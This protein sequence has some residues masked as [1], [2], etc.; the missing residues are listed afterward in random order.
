M[1][2]SSL[3]YDREMIHVRDDH[4]I[5]MDAF[6]R[7]RGRCAFDAKSTSFLAAL[8]AGS[9]W[10][11]HAYDHGAGDRLVGFLRAISDGVATA[12]VS[13][14]MVDPDYR[15]RGVGRAMMQRIMHGRDEIKFVLHSSREAAAFY[16]AV[17][18]LPATDMMMRDRR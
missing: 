9:R 3:P 7:L 8:V 12:Y 2:D 6:A 18:F 5:D 15:R 10:I 13:S 17:G 4:N 16:S 14:V 1:V 11:A